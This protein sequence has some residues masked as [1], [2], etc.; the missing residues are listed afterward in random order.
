[1]SDEELGDSL[2]ICTADHDPDGTYSCENTSHL[3]RE[4]YQVALNL[5]LPLPTLECGCPIWGG[6]A[7][8]ARPAGKHIASLMAAKAANEKAIAASHSAMRRNG[9]GR[10]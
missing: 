10:H 4:N 7:I 2:T 8:K 3:Q 6:M 5:S 1:M 9:N